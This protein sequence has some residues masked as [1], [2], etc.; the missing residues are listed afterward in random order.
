MSPLDKYLKNA[1]REE[2]QWE[3]AETTDGIGM[4]GV[5]IE[6]VNLLKRYASITKES[7]N[8]FEIDVN[9]SYKTLYNGEYT[10]EIIEYRSNR[11]SAREFAERFI[12]Q[13]II[14]DI[15][16]T[17]EQLKMMKHM[18]GLDYK[19]VPY[20]NYGYFYQSQDILEDLIEKGLAKRYND[21]QNESH[22]IYYLTRL[23]VEMAIK[24]PI[25]YKKYKGL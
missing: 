1:N 3:C 22:I 21:G 20:R 16:V 15:N 8:E 14:K 5:K 13:D 9:L 24:K 17:E 10:W 7:E 18:I 2:F 25:S 4:G 11:N 19:K 12:C 6:E 23:G